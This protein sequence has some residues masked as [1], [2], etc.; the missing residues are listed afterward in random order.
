MALIRNY[1]IER[2]IPFSRTVTVSSGGSALDL[3][4]ATIAGKIR[5]ARSLPGTGAFVVSFTTAIVGLA[6]AGVFTFSLPIA[7]TLLIGAG[8]AY[9]Y[10][11]V[12]TFSPTSKRRPLA[13]ILTGV[14]S[15][16]T[17]VDPV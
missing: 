15:S 6:T 14:E 8:A 11:I 4:L 13:G 5:V 7:D 17:H 9:D 3:T 16:T 1:T 10:D 2:G 12:I